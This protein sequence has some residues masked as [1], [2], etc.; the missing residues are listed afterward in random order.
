MQSERQKADKNYDVEDVNERRQAKVQVVDDEDQE[1]QSVGAE[2]LSTEVHGM[3]R[4]KLISSLCLLW[5]LIVND[6]AL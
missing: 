1:A 5:T 2:F 6:D 4:V 3:L